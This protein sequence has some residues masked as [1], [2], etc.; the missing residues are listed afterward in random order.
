MTDFT[1]F[2][3]CGLQE[4]QFTHFGRDLK[5]SF[6]SC[7]N[8]DYIGALNCER[9]KFF[10]FND[11]DREFCDENLAEIDEGFFG[12][13]IGDVIIE[14]IDDHYK[15]RFEMLHEKL[16]IHCANLSVIKP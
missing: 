15:I 13:Y 3:D 6:C 4:I 16:I 9:V 11:F 2:T 10:Q 7:Y 12:A 14:K 1:S 8:G 5:V